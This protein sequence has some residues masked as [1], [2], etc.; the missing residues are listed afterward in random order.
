M[1]MIRL[2]VDTIHGPRLVEFEGKRHSPYRAD[3]AIVTECEAADGSFVM[4]NKERGDTDLGVLVQ[5]GEPD[6]SPHPEPPNPDAGRPLTL[7]EALAISRKP[8]RPGSD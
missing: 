5:R 6:L 4:Y 3:D 8:S 7:D 2:I 1:K